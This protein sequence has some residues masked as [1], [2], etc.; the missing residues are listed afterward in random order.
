MGNNFNFGRVLL[1]G[2]P[3]FALQTWANS[4]RAQFVFPAF[5]G[6]VVASVYFLMHSYCWVLV[7]LQLPSAIVCL[8]D[9]LHELEVAEVD[10]VHGLTLEHFFYFYL[11]QLL[12]IILNGFKARVARWLLR[13][14]VVLQTVQRR[15]GTQLVERHR[16]LIFTLKWTHPLF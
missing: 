7:E 12:V 13:L 10:D 8:T 6:G 16:T 9:C 4:G 3:P 2:L 11:A 1:Q 5:I 15:L 14:R